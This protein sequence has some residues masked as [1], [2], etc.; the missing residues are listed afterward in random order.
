VVKQRM[1][2]VRRMHAS[3]MSFQQSRPSISSIY[4]MRALANGREMPA[5]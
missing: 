4:F 5:R 1:T 2:G 3:S